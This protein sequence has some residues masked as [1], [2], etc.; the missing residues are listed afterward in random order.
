[1]PVN[2]PCC[3]VYAIEHQLQPGLRLGGAAGQC[4]HPQDHVGAA[5][6]HSYGT[7]LGSKQLNASASVAGTF[8][9]PPAAGM[10][11]AAGAQTL[12]VTFNPTNITDYNSVT[13]RT[14]S[15]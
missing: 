15:R 2:R 8:V 1:M 7:A 9:Y 3:S 6:G 14:N 12:S 5:V 13:V 11:L 10:V 4:G